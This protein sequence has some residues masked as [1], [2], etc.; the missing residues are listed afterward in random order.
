MNNSMVRR[1]ATMTW[2][3]TSANLDSELK[4]RWKEVIAMEEEDGRKPLNA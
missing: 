4:G 3:N 1:S 2:L